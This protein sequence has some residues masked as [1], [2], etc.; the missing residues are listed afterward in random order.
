MGGWGVDAYLL[1]GRT[2]R[3]RLTHGFAAAAMLCILYM[4]KR[5]YLYQRIAVLSFAQTS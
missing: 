1:P 3:P 4:Y 5:V 2:E